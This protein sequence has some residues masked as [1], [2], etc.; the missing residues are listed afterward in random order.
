MKPTIEYLNAR[1]AAKPP[2]AGRRS[3]EH[4]YLHDPAEYAPLDVWEKLDAKA[5]SAWSDLRIN[6]QVYWDKLFA[7][8]G[9]Q[10]GYNIEETF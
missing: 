7:Q 4:S 1:A 8:F 5:E 3:K 9:L 2:S 6:S 10:Q